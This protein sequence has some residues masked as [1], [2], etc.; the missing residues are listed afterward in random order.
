MRLFLLLGV[1]AAQAASGAVS[2]TNDIAPIF[3]QKCIACHNEQKA[4]GNFQL[5]TFDALNKGVKGE[6][7]I[8]PTKPDDSTLYQLLVETDEDSRMPQNDDPL[9][10]PQI[11]LIKQ[12][13]QEGA[14]FD[15]PDAKASI[16]TFVASMNF[17]DPPTAY[18]HPIPVLALSFNPAGTELAS[19]GYHEV[20]IWNVAEARLLRRIRSLPQRIQALEYSPDG[21]TLAIASG[22][23][24]RI[25][26]TY[27]S[28]GEN[29]RP[30]HTS[31]DVVLALT[32]SRDGATLATG[33]ADNAIRVFEVASGKLKFKTEQHAD[34]VMSL[35]FHPETNLIISASR[36]KTVRVI[37]TLNGELE[38]TYQGHTE[39]V[40][41]GVFS[42]DGKRAYSAGRDKK[43][44][45]WDIKE[46]KKAGEASVDGDVYRLV[47]HGKDLFACGSDK[48]VRHFRAGDKPELVRA[49]S[50]HQDVVYALAFS[51][52]TRRLA[53]GGYD[54]E[55]RIWNTETGESVAAF[56][57]TPNI[58]SAQHLPKG[59]DAAGVLG[60]RAN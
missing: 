48:L 26:Q 9:P 39:G 56:K 37:N 32:F 46:G 20:L 15:G 25:G 11:A 10:A 44:H 33:G 40:F 29:L 8:V 28:E 18:P 42:D 57:A 17:P 24:G 49:F 59:V 19:S 5:H 4:K 12:W 30:L 34:W 45:V 22:T 51:P 35:A 1:V 41:A 43:I 60:G 36:D 6:P 54:G 52:A 31:P 13:I 55:V 47:R 7:V 27:L 16:K 14:K 2:F 38:T 58:R 21:K 53:S 3:A 23:P 50:G